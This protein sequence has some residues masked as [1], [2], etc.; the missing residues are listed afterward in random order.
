MG[1]GEVD[2]MLCWPRIILG[3]IAAQLL[4][5]GLILLYLLVNHD[6]GTVTH[7]GSGTA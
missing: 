4:N 3:N 5:L 2:S 7:T 1:L 6:C